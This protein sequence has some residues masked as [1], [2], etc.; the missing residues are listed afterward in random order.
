MRE[1]AHLFSW[2]GTIGVVTDYFQKNLR[3]DEKK[4]PTSVS[5]DGVLGR[6]NNWR[7]LDSRTHETANT[8]PTLNA[9]PP[10]LGEQNQNR[11]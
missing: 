7:S 2:P 6:P 11:R 10:L 1:F 9:N 5:T 4:N 3:S 8:M